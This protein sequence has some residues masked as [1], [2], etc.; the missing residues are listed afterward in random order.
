MAAVA[1]TTE[2]KR[3]KMSVAEL[4]D[5]H[6]AAIEQ[7]NT[8]REL[9]K[10]RRRHLLDTDGSFF[11]VLK[12][13]FLNSSSNIMYA[14]TFFFSIF[15]EIFRK[16]DKLLFVVAVASF[17]AAQG[18]TAVSFGQ[19]DLVCCRTLQGHTGKVVPFSPLPNFPL[20]FK[21]F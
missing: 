3:E 13:V 17:A 7:V 5:R 16:I 4:R 8:L 1:A 9:L 19:T 18:K 15:M 21:F 11:S 10:Q 14:F 12:S 6:V 2:E 20:R